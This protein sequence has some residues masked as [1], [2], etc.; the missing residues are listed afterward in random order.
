MIPIAADKWSCFFICT[1]YGIIAKVQSSTDKVQ[2]LLVW[3]MFFS[4]SSDMLFS[5]LCYPDC[6]TQWN[7]H[8][9]F[10]SHQCK[11]FQS[12]FHSISLPFLMFYLHCTKWGYCA[13]SCSKT[14]VSVF[15]RY[16]LFFYQ[17]TCS[18]VLKWIH[19]VTTFVRQ[20]Q[21]WCVILPIPA[22][23]N[24]LLLNWR[25]LRICVSSCMRRVRIVPSFERKVHRRWDNSVW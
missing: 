14:H 5:L 19:M 25:A 10:I 16:C 24:S 22:G 1:F 9:M 13:I 20:S 17:Q 3:N 18:S 23:M 2:I 12:S 8:L 15:Y 11:I 21:N 7:L 4:S 6:F